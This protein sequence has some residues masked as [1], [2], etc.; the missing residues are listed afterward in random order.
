MTN[1]IDTTI[2][3]GRIRITRIQ[4]G[5]T[6]K[7]L[8]QR[9]GVSV[10]Q[11]YLIESG[12]RH[13]STETLVKISKVLNV[14]YGWLKTGDERQ[15]VYDSQSEF[16]YADMR[17]ILLLLKWQKPRLFPDAVTN[18][19]NVTP[20]TLNRLIDGNA[21][22]ESQSYHAFRLLA[23]HVDKNGLHKAFRKLDELLTTI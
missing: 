6:V 9:V 17:L 14:S 19:L 16:T 15:S 23:Q 20:E 21:A 13:P 11:I 12:H 10:N 1:R 5:L 2:I 3:G 8:A 7:E 22:Y 18:M 4:H